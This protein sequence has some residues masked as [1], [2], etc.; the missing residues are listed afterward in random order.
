MLDFLNPT[1]FTRYFKALRNHYLDQKLLKACEKGNNECVKKYLSK[2]ANPNAAAIAPLSGRP[3][4]TALIEAVFW[5]DP[6]VVELLLGAGADP[7]LQRIVCP[8]RKSPLSERDLA[9][10][11]E[12]CILLLVPNVGRVIQD[13]LNKRKA[14]YDAC[15]DLL[16]KNGAHIHIQ[17]EDVKAES[18]KITWLP[19]KIKEWEYISCEAA[20]DKAT[21]RA[22]NQN[23][24]LRL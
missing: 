4:K 9:S 7:N 1:K 18:L 21:A 24:A 17:N 22:T 5:G 13:V 10:P 15:V 19:K 2:G 23:K 6:E 14:K 16:V 8:D 20:L 12:I 11:F 3:Q